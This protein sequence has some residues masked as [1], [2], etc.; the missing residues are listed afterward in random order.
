MTETDHRREAE[1]LTSRA[2]HFTYGD[3]ADPVTGAALAAEA[4][5]HATLALAD[6]Q[7]GLADV[8]A[9]RI[10]ELLRPAPEKNTAAESV[11]AF[12]PVTA[13]LVALARALRELPTRRQILD[14]LDE[15]GELSVC[16][17]DPREIASQVAALCYLARIP[18]PA[19]AEPLVV[20]RAAHDAIGVGLYDTAKEARRHCEDLVSR[21]YPADVTVTFDWLADAEYGDLAAADLVVQISGGNE[22]E[23]GY[24]VTPLEVATAYDPDGDE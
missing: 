5:V 17:E 20:Y 12:T 21:E 16:D 23:T 6:A 14:G 18:A 2:H 3:G 22:D 19:P 7:S 13:V 4:Q 15:L 8:L 9:R 11:A 10:A 24:I 1:R